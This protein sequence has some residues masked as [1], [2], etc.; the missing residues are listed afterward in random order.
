[1]RLVEGLDGSSEAL[2]ESIAVTIA[3]TFLEI[4]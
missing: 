3:V 1:M 4:A 2:A